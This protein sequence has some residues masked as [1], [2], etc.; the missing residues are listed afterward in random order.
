MIKIPGSILEKIKAQGRAEAPN[1]ACGYLAGVDGEVQEIIPMKNADESPT[2]FS[3][4]PEEQFAALQKA[5][6]RGVDLFSVYHSHPATPPRMSEEDI[7]LAYDTSITYLIYSMLTDEIKAFQI[8]T[9][10]QVS[11]TT[12]KIMADPET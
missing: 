1:E 12:V 3:F 8:N 11:E 9:E 10:K 6:A 4:D 2:H 5:T 7:R